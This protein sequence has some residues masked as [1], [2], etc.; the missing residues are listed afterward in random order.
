MLFDVGLFSMSAGS[1]RWVDR[2]LWHRSKGH[3]ARLPEVHYREKR[4]AHFWISLC[5]RCY[6]SAL[7]LVD[8]QGVCYRLAEERGTH[9]MLL[10]RRVRPRLSFF[11]PMLPA[12]RKGF[13]WLLLHCAR[14]R[15]PNGGG[16]GR[17]LFIQPAF[18]CS[19]ARHVLRSVGLS[20]RLPFT[21]NTSGCIW[22]STWSLSAACCLLVCAALV[23]NCAGTSGSH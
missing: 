12:R 15:T 7:C 19:Q 1:P 22:T 11:P 21:G 13:W 14:H 10:P 4:G 17:I 16:V 5:G 20:F 6:R 18:L 8:H 9:R 23:L 2:G 3:A